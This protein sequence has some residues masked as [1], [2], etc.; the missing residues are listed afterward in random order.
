[1]DRAML[2]LAYGAGLRVSEWI[3]LGVKEVSVGSVTSRLLS[4]S[5][6][7][8]SVPPV[9]R[10]SLPERALIGTFTTSSVSER[11]TKV[12]SETSFA[13]TTSFTQFMNSPLMVMFSPG[14]ALAVIELTV[15][16]TSKLIRVRDVMS[17]SAVLRISATWRASSERPVVH[18]EIS[19]RSSS[20]Q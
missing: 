3:G 7:S 8:G 20:I 1:A 12:V 19:S 17:P 11:L 18:P 9:D 2:E 13:N 4:V 5:I 15:T 16:G 10:I 6:V 14:F